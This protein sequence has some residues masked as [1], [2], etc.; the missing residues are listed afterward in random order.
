LLHVSG[1]SSWRLIRSHRRR[2]TGLFEIFG[3]GGLL[4]GVVLRAASSP[5]SRDGTTLTGRASTPQSDVI[6]IVAGLA[7]L[8]SEW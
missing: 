7:V 3:Y 4:A 8:M 6:A 1:F 5:P 2:R